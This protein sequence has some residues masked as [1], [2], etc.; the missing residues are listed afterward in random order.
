MASTLLLA[1]VFVLDLV[2]FAL[3]VAAEQ[4]RSTFMVVTEGN[5]NYCHYGSNIA[6]GLGVGS[7]IILL[8][9][10]AII[11]VVTRCLCCG[12]A[13]RP[14]GNR[15][16]AI[17]LFITSWVT[18][19]IAASCLLAGSARN[20]RH[21]KDRTTVPVIPSC[22]TLRKGVFGA[23]AAFIVF[24][25]IVSELYYVNYSKANSGPP[26]HARDSGVTMANM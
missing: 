4:K 23:G 22:V 19:I 14:S 13:M 20:T 26:S 1:V 15:S 24:T 17:C 11:M 21:T 18:F 5:Q 6:T 3:A 7:F 25:G 12:Q 16:W 9:S 2:A 10:Q 8:A